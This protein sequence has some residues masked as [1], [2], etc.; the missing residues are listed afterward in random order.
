MN[1]IEGIQLIPVLELEPFKFS[2]E[3]R[4]SPSGALCDPDE[5]FRYWSV[6]LADSGITGLQPLRHGSWHVP[7]VNFDDSNNLQRF[8]EKTFQDWGGIDSLSDPDCKPVLDGGLVLRCSSSNTFIEPGCCA[9]LGDFRNWKDAV[10]YRGS[11]WQMLWI[12]HPWISVRYQSPWLVLSDPHE[13]STP[14][15]RWAVIPEELNR[16]VNDANTDRERF[17]REIAG[18]LRTLVYGEGSKVMGR[19]LCGFYE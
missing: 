11:D 2:A 5:W 18:M 12:G 13:S 8:L 19:K 9:D 7:I 3:N 1:V 10:T 17:S 16:A 14:T 4:K 15:D 6:S